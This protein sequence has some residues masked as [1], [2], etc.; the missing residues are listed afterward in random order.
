MKS[1]SALVYIIVPTYNRVRTTLQ[2]I[3]RIR[4][5]LGDKR[6]YICDSASND[7]TAEAVASIPGIILVNTGEKAWWSAAINAGIKMAFAD[8]AE[9]VIIM[10]DDIVFD[11]S[12]LL[13]LLDVYQRNPT[14]IV[15]PMQQTGSGS[16]AGTVYKG[17]FKKAEIYREAA[18]EQVVHTSNGCC[19]LI[20]KVVIDKIGF[21][22]EANCPH[23]YGDTE[24]QLRA[25][26]AGFKT[27]VASNARI[28]QVGSTDYLGRLYSQSIFS[29]EGSPLY[30]RAYHGFGR[31]L[32][33]G[34]IPFILLGWSYH[35][36]FIKV[37]AKILLLRASRLLVTLR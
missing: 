35:L 29:Y 37:L 2:Y 6:L 7:G 33:K 22:D 14:S 16:Y 30:I 27:I 17:M 1:K 12:L 18:K 19:L 3:D 23:L 21:M 9:S 26:N 36:D 15:T 34:T 25:H 5:S 13:K 4:K 20:P 24:F 11:N 32:Y 31:A 28:V 8:G 10:N